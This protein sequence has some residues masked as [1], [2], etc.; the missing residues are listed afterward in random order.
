MF[1][2]PIIRLHDR[3]VCAPALFS[4]LPLAASGIASGAESTISSEDPEIRLDSHEG[5]SCAVLGLGRSGMAAARALV[6]A[7]A[8]VQ[9]WDDDAEPRKR[10]R[11]AGYQVMSPEE[12]DWPGLDFLLLSPGIPHTWP[13]PH[14]AALRARET[15]TEIIGDVELLFRA[16]SQACPKARFIGVTGTNGKS[17]TTALITHILQHG[18]FR[19]A[20]GGNIG[21]PALSL[22][23][24]YDAYVL[25]IS[26]YQLEL[27]PSAAFDIAV[28][29]NL[30]PDH[31]DRHGGM[32]N[33]VAAKR[34]ILEGAGV[35][36]I[37]IDDPLS[38]E[39]ATEMT[40]AGRRY[41]P[42]SGRT[43][44]PGGIGAVGIGAM[45]IGATGTEGIRDDR[46]DTDTAGLV[47]C[48][49]AKNP[50][51]PGVHNAQNA[52][53]A[54]AAVLLTEFASTSAS[55]KV[56]ISRILGEAV[57]SFPGLPHRHEPVPSGDGIRYIND[58]KATNAEAAAYAIACHETLYWIAGGQAKEGGWDILE[59]YFPRIRG[60]F[61]IGKAADAMAAWID[62]R[63]PTKISGDL[64]TALRQA[65]E[66][67]MAESIASAAGAAKAGDAPIV[68][69][70]PACASFDQFKDFAERGDAFRDLVIR[71]AGS[72]DVD[73][74]NAAGREC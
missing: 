23:A 57:S 39:I 74:G 44:V 3:T 34:R 19:A 55:K 27:T 10:A 59:D 36:V 68:L 9:V 8:A 64:E 63:V 66:A 54:C 65:R 52:A 16:R 73:P 26:S 25:E 37:G 22:P 50:V 18:G 4:G 58:S 60:V 17:T 31:L 20:S 41:V 38:A 6:T 35:A 62:G 1:A 71:V 61:L 5:I 69:L 56:S 47:L 14:P 21:R 33:Y 12:W 72:G 40:L 24:G 7:K 67:A 32:D 53:A 30:G 11:T 28:L 45:G 15:G 2:S 13:E 42:V 46:K 70:A 51:L 48:T 49:P 43:P 29:L